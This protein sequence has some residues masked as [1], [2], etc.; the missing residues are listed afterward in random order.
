MA[1]FIF[2]NGQKLNKR[3]IGEFIGKADIFNQSMLREAR[4]SRPHPRRRCACAR[5]GRARGTCID[6]CSTFSKAEN[7]SLA[8]QPAGVQ[9]CTNLVV[10]EKC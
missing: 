2:D 4:T 5:D 8:R 10:L 7:Y 6:P 9:K 1:Q 3:K